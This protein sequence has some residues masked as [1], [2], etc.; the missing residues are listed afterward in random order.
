MRSIV[1][2]FLGMLIMF[3]KIISG[4]DVFKKKKEGFI[5]KNTCVS[6]SVQINNYLLLAESFRI[7]HKLDS[8]MYYA[9]LSLQIAD[10]NE[11]QIYRGKAFV[12]LGGIYYRMTKYDTAITLNQQAID[13]FI[14]EG[15]KNETRT[16]LAHLGAIYQQKNNYE[17]ALNYYLESLEI[18]HKINDLKKETATMFNIALLYY[19]LSLNK[20]SIEYCNKVLELVLNSELENY[21]VSYTYNLLAANYHGRKDYSKAIENYDKSLQIAVKE[22]NVLGQVLSLNS[23]GEIN[24]EYGNFIEA[25]NQLRK[26]LSLLHSLDSELEVL[27]SV[28]LSLAKIEMVKKNY[29]KSLQLAHQGLEQARKHQQTEFIRDSYEMLSEI[30]KNMGQFDKALQNYVSFKVLFDSISNVKAAAIVSEI[31]TKYETEKKE[32]EIEILEKNEKIQEIKL[33]QKTLERNL[34][35]LLILA[36]LFTLYF[37]VRIIKQK[38][39][40]EKVEAT[41]KIEKEKQQKEKLAFEIKQKKKNDQLKEEIDRLE[42]IGQ[43]EFKEQVDDISNFLENIKPD[44]KSNSRNKINEFLYKLEVK[45]QN[46][47]NIFLEKFYEE[48]PDFKSTLYSKLEKK[49]VKKLTKGN[50]E[51]CALI[52]TGF[53]ENKIKDIL[54]IDTKRLTQKKKR[55]LE[56]TE[57]TNFDEL[58]AFIRSI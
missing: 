57:F 39:K 31:E 8:A 46:K 55:L 21:M 4:D 2:I 27:S 25:E 47:R 32:Q 3:S 33:K 49:I 7:S 51:L 44:M 24:M 48:N 54:E 35:T 10:K 23:L 34:V 26:A 41:R 19:Q 22:K 29:N 53:S 58:Y 50:I 45:K 14:G 43:K 52:Y 12:T 11:W 16:A 37:Y 30:Y 1:T 42:K 9:K 36:L 6:D 17:K 20:K 40:L 28:I 15:R 56:R 18:S 13:I 5:A 38:N